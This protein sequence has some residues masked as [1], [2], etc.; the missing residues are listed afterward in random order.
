MTSDGNIDTMRAGGIIIKTCKY[1]QNIKKK[2]KFIDFV[3]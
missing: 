2:I 3:N 1:V